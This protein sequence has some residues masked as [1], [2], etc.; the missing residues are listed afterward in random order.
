MR[1][2]TPTNVRPAFLR[3]TGGLLLAGSVAFAI[4]ASVLSSTFNW[5][6]ILREPAGVV[7]PAFAAFSMIG[8]LRWVFVV[9]ALAHMHVAGIVTTQAAADAAWTARLLLQ[10]ANRLT[11]PARNHPDTTID[12]TNGETRPPTVAAVGRR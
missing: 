7:V 5:P 6:D 4:A 1:Q 8:F 12:E 10:R 11:A 9:P 3:V 2:S